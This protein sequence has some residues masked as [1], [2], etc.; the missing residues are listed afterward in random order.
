MKNSRALIMRAA[1]VALWLQ[2]G[3]VAA[4]RA[5]GADGEAAVDDDAAQPG[6]DAAID[7]DVAASQDATATADTGAKT[8]TKVGADVAVKVLGCKADADCAAVAVLPCQSATCNKV[9]GLCEQGSKADGENCAPAAAHP[10]IKSASCAAGVCVP[11][12]VPCDDGNDCTKD[13]CDPASDC[14]HEAIESYC[15]DKDPCTTADTC[16][17]KVCKGSNV[18]CDDKNVCTIDSCQA[19]LCQHDK[20]PA[21]AKCDDGNKCTEG[22][23]CKDGSCAGTQKNCDDGNECTFDT[24][25]LGGLCVH[26]P[27]Q[28]L[29]VACSDGSTCGVQGI[30]SSEKTCIVKPKSCDDKNPCT[31]D[32]CVE[33]KGCENLA[34]ALVCVGSAACDGAGQCNAGKCV[35]AA[36]DCNDANVCTDDSCDAVAGCQHVAN[37]A[38]CGDGNPCTGN[39]FCKDA[40][41]NA[42]ATDPC[43]DG[44]ACT[45]DSCTPQQGC[46]HAP[47]ALG[48]TCA[49]GTCVAGLC[50]GSAPN[51]GLCGFAESSGADCPASGGACAAADSACLKTC[52]AGKCSAPA[53]ACAADPT[54]AAIAACAD[55]CSTPGCRLDCMTGV[56]WASLSQANALHACGQ[57]FC[58]ANNWIGKK[59]SG[60]ETL[61]STCTTACEASMCP[62]LSLSCPTGS[63]CAAIRSCLLEC[64]NGDTAC[65]A[66]CKAK[67]TKGGKEAELAADLDDCSAIACH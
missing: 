63:N 55:A 30:C 40:A 49:V 37:S 6:E 11:V 53:A 33:G 27:T 34:N 39:D 66:A 47:V 25:N 60:S 59:C 17:E 43:G 56:P 5:D 32:S 61:L 54:C 26:D 62:V 16:S 50:I 1:F 3:C 18:S 20:A 4:P 57:A 65:F 24:C 28:G 19:G 41:C 14:T 15:D 58:V 42:G 12:P 44:D 51:D 23:A 29:A 67:D 21:A 38:G 8:D 2:V 52:M 48:T 10:C 45:A 7:Q 31:D 36:K 13:G 64:A 9:T 22:E 35:V 46:Q